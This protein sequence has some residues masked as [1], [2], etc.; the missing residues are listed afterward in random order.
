MNTVT[1]AEEDDGGFERDRHRATTV[2]TFRGLRVPVASRV[3]NQRTPR[4]S[5]HASWAAVRPSAGRSHRV[6]PGLMLI[7][8]SAIVLVPIRGCGVSRVA[9]SPGEF[10]CTAEEMKIIGMSPH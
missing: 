4:A 6:V 7:L 5:P 10:G 1:T 8:R 9:L 3:E 2:A